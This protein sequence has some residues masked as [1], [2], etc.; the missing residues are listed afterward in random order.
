MAIRE[1][2]KPA[3]KR[4]APSKERWVSKDPTLLEDLLAIARSIPKEEL[5]KFPKDGSVNLDH[6]IY[7]TP[8]KKP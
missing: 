4:K 1:P 7:G 8:K 6:Y 5:A 3:R 2:Q